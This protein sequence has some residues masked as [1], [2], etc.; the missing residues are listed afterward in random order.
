MYIVC[1]R[2]VGLGGGIDVQR[3]LPS[4]LLAVGGKRPDLQNSDL[5]KETVARSVLRGKILLRYI[6]VA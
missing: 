1:R 2:G 4:R 5:D 3:R 6:L